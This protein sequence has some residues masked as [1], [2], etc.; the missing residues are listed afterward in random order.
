MR[1]AIQELVAKLASCTRP[2]LRRTARERT[3]RPPWGLC[4]LC[5]DP[6]PGTRE[7][8]LT[9]QRRRSAQRGSYSALTNDVIFQPPTRGSR[10]S[11]HVPVTGGPPGHSTRLSPSAA[12]PAVF[13]AA[14][15][16]AS[17]FAG[18]GGGAISVAIASSAL[19]SACHMAIAA[20]AP[21]PPPRLHTT[22]S[23][24]CRRCL[25]LLC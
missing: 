17:S 8:V 19:G 3:F 13:G 12:Q 22:S 6:S 4:D 2:G 16:S 11:C 25:L 9:R 21:V 1:C 5:G 7:I 14:G 10:I 23:A 15:G 18:A 20:S 24:S